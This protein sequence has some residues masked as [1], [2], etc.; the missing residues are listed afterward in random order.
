MLRFVFFRLNDQ[1]TTKLP[2][3]ILAYNYRG[4]EDALETTDQLESV[5]DPFLVS[6]V[7]KLISDVCS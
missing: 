2:V 4:C 7:I 6:H 5:T 3:S 1:V